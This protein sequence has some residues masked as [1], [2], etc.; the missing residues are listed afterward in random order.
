MTH[1][2]IQEIHRKLALPTIRNESG[3]IIP[4][5][6]SE[7]ELSFIIFEMMHEMREENR[8]KSGSVIQKNWNKMSK[9]ERNNLEL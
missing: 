2:E 7:K 5:E 8:R 3:K 9:K 1:T 6:F 4:T